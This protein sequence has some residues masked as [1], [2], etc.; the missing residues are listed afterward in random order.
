[1]YCKFSIVL[2]S[3]S[4][5]MRLFA[6]TLLYIFSSLVL[7]AQE[8]SDTA[9][10]GFAVNKS[11]ID[12][13]WGNNLDAMSTLIDVL[14]S[15]ESD[16]ELS[17]TSVQF[18]GTSS[19]EGSRELNCRLS[20]RRINAVER[21]LRG[22]VAIDR[23]LISRNSEYIMW[24]IL[25][26]DIAVSDIQYRDEVLAII[27]NGE[28]IVDYWRKGETID[29]RVN[30]LRWMRNGALWKTLLYQ[31]FPNMRKVCVIITTMRTPKPEPEP[32]IIVGPES[33]PIIFEPEP[34]IVK[35]VVSTVGD[36]TWQRHC[37]IKSNGIGWLMLI[38]NAAFEYDFSPHWSLSV[39][40]Y[41]SA[42]NYFTYKVKFRTAAI[43]PEIRYWFGEN[44]YDDIL[45]LRG[46]AVRPRVNAY[47]GVHFSI[48]QYN[49]ALDGDYRRQDH[50]GRTP[51]YGGGISGG[52]R[53]PLDHQG[54]W[55]MEFTGGVGYYHLY[56]DKFVNEPNGRE[57]SST[58]KNF[59]CLDN[60]AVSVAYR[61]DIKKAK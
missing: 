47:I 3:K 25:R 1:M 29:E 57:V 43:Q 23:S 17:I 26:D 21:A 53:V 61:F 6:T 42:L 24:Q 38:A 31:Y 56:Y 19:P 33:E 46:V 16:E 9:Y 22:A 40:I 12:M 18:Y 5:K 11:E 51:A 34:I 7:C 2:K 13:S 60:F 28:M 37:Y 48:A 27:D 20:E 32:L 4:N 39:P 50:D 30:K 10:I 44:G 49:Y 59:F 45:G 36:K 55:F 15:A 35:E 14:Q 58:K 8:K 54:R 52:V 41:Y